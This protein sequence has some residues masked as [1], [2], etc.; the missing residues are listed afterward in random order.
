MFPNEGQQHF[1]ASPSTSKG[2]EWL[3]A[4]NQFPEGNGTN[5]YAFSVNCPNPLGNGGVATPGA[6]VGLPVTKPYDTQ[7][8]IQGCVND[9][10]G[11]AFNFNQRTPLPHVF[12][13]FYL[14]VLYM[15]PNGSDYH[16][17]RQGPPPYKWTNKPTAN[18]T[19]N[20][21]TCDFTQF[22]DV[23][24]QVFGGYQ[25]VAY[26]TC[27]IGGVYVTRAMA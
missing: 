22:G 25:F 18:Q 16:F 6:N 11:L 1:D 3:V 8:L 5:C 17:V 26:L 27:P 20:N 24:P 14:V 15:N 2:F 13:G 9:G 19:P 4:F 21:A 10:L 7:A 23:P 12:P